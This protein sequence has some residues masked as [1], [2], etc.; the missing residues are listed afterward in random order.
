[1]CWAAL[2]L[3]CMGQGVGGECGLWG[4]GSFPRLEPPGRPTLPRTIR[5]VVEEEKQLLPLHS[6]RPLPP[7]GSLGPT[8]PILTISTFLQNKT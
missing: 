8:P 4:W 2:S 6:P 7:H 5:P 3:P 1:M